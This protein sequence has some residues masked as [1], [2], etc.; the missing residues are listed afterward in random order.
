MLATTA[1]NAASPVNAHPDFVFYEP[2]W[3]KLFHCYEGTGGFA[4]GTYLIAHPREWKDHEKDAPTVPTKKLLG[5]RALAR[6]ENLARAILDAKRAALFRE[7]PTRLIGGK[8]TAEADHPLRQWWENVDGYGCGIDDWVQ[9][10]WT[11]SATMGHT[12]HVMD[13][14]SMDTVPQTKAD[15]GDLYLRAYWP[16][17]MP[18]WTT[19]DR[20][21][22]NAVALR[23]PVLP[24]SIDDM[25]AIT[26]MKINL[27]VLTDTTW[28]LRVQGEKGTPLDHGFGRLPV[29]LLYSN[30]RS[31][32]IVGRSVLDSPQLFIDDYNLTSEIRE[33][34][35]SQ[36]FGW[37]NV[38]LGTGDNTTSVQK[39]QELLGT[40]TGT[41][42]VLFS[43]GPAH[44][45]QPS[46]ANVEVYQK[47]R[48][49]LRRNI[50]RLCALPWESDSKDAEAMGSMKLKREDMNQ[51]LAAYAD[52]CEKF[53][54]QI[55]ELWFRGEYGPDRWEAELEKADVVIRYPDTFD[56]TPFIDIL[57]QAQAG[58]TL[59]MDDMSA[60]FRAELRR[61]FVSKFLPDATPDVIATIDAEIKAAAEKGPET[62][63]ATLKALAAQ[64]QT[65][66]AKPP[67][68]PAEPQP[69]SEAA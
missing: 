30:R 36:T 29:A 17:D 44:F 32:G 35:R 8:T 42:N 21:I 38:E 66:Q 2:V 57:E 1:G 37:L 58:M 27:R 60:T 4:D 67:K 40:G 9:G 23:E 11:V 7:T 69:V 54:Y 47:E 24:T 50:F 46:T 6:Y 16:L 31:V 22:L 14:P 5:R 52:E 56:V 61:R 15:Q 51:I 28:E 55:V 43:P 3:R 65:P 13:R 49:A 62:V 45:I 59:G 19:N 10:A 64:L 68:P 25:A 39:A 33:L 63:N 18:A 26:N 12:V 53:E 34:L 20:G 48:E 41:D